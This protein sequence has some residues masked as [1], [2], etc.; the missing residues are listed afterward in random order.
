MTASLR[1]GACPSLSAPMQT[2]DGLLAR[3]NPPDGALSARQLAGV[4]AAARGFGNGILE[5]SARG[6]LQ[7]R[8]LTEGSA[9]GLA[10]AIAGL[11]IAVK[12]G[13]DVRT[14]PL[15]GLDAT[16]IAD[17]RPLAEQIRI[18]TQH[19]KSRLA[20]KMSVVADGGGTLTLSD[21]IADVRLEA[22]AGGEWLVRVGGIGAAAKTL[23]KGDATRAADTAIAVLQTLAE[24]GSQARGRDLDGAALAALRKDLDAA[25]APPPSR[26]RSP[27]GRFA[28]RDGGFARGFSLAFGQID[29]EALAELA[30]GVDP[31]KEFRLAPGRGLLALGLLEEEDAALIGAAGRL[32]LVTQ[33]DDP[34]LRVVACAGAPA[35]ASAHLPTKAIARAVAT[36]LPSDGT[37][38]HVSGCAKQC[39]KPA[40][41]SVALIGGRGGFQIV[42]DGTAA[43]AGTRALLLRVAQAHGAHPLRQRA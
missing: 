21:L 13:I 8:G 34:R 29:A 19:L 17:P 14:G 3:L 15:A 41:P 22:L 38:V 31:A 1:R 7:I 9:V 37:R 20:P 2:G 36:Q 32:G 24:I 23:G 35:C 16:E 43:A 25:E 30:Q 42:A 40:G 33:P 39:A 27:V 10:D 4:A 5:I 26:P 6:G 12:P 11:G 18:A 28:L